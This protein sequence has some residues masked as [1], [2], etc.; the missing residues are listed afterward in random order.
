M[1][2]RPIGCSLILVATVTV[3]IVVAYQAYQVLYQPFTRRLAIAF[4]FFDTSPENVFRRFILGDYKQHIP[5]PPEVT[6]IEGIEGSPAGN[7]G[8]QGPVF[9][10]FDASQSFNHKLIEQEYPYGT[11]SQISCNQFFETHEQQT[12]PIDFPELFE[13]WKPK[14]VVFATCYQLKLVDNYN[15]DAARYLLVDNDTNQVYFYRTIV[16]GAFGPD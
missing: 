4:V 12:Y 9:L 8:W 7:S 3:F 13:W 11:Y 16:A 6:Q 1:K 15:K 5:I 10:R 2:W 14:D